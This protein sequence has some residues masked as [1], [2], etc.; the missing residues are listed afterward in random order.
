MKLIKINLP[1]DHEIVWI[2]CLHEGNAHQH[3]RGIDEA[4]DYIA[5]KKNRY[6]FIVGD[7][8]EAIQIN[9]KRYEHDIHKK[10]ASII[11]QYNSATDRL[12]KIKNKVLGSVAGNHDWKIRSYGDF[13]EEIFCRGLEIPYGT[14]SCKLIVSDPKGKIQY[15]SFITHGNGSLNSAHAEPIMRDASLQTQVKRKLSRE[16]M[17]D[18]HLQVI[19]HFHRPIIVPPHQSLYLTDDGARIKQNYHA[20]ADPRAKYI[21]EDLRW[22]IAVPGFIR[23]YSKND[24]TS[25]YVERAG[26]SPVELGYLVSHAQAGKTISVE[27]RLV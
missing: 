6:C 23:K 9:D 21:P 15:K 25:G 26:L 5:S 3:S 19:A 14:Y 20:D 22:H 4:V 13:V 11:G 2:A 8:A 17:S 24:D 18:C 1:I 27:K 7:I 10:K 16:L 12:K